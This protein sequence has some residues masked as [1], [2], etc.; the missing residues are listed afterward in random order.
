MALFRIEDRKR[1]VRIEST[2]FEANEMQERKDLQNMLKTQI[3]VIAPEI[4]IVAEEFGEWEDS[5]RRIDLSEEENARLWAEE[6]ERR[7]T[8]WDQTADRTRSA[9]D[10]FRDARACVG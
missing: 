4:L 10:V 6:A 8:S 3:E 1:I 2:T 7:D 9:Q 5:R